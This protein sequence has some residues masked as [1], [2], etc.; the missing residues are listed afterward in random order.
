M[1]LKSA[2]EEVYLEPCEHQSH[3]LLWQRLKLPGCHRAD[4]CA[5]LLPMEAN[6]D[7][8]WSLAST[9]N[10]SGAGHVLR[11]ATLIAG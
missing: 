11:S 2:I 3:H 4:R 10:A 8:A 7:G 5:Q 9:L 6:Q 1:L